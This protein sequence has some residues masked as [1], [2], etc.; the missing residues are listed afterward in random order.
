MFRHLGMGW[1][2]F[3]HSHLKLCRNEKKRRTHFCWPA[4]YTSKHCAC[5]KS[6]ILYLKHGQS[7]MQVSFCQMGGPM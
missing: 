4:L 6:D 7:K 1:E 2:G 5:T 3:G